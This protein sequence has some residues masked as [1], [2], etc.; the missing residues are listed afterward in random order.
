MATDTLTGG[1]RPVTLPN[2]FPPMPAVARILSRFD[3]DQLSSFIAVAI[4]LADAM[5]GD[6]DEEDGDSHEDDDPR[7]AA[8]IEWTALEPWRRAT[9]NL[10]GGDHEDAEPNGDE[11]D[12]TFA[13]DEDARPYWTQD[14][15]AGC[16]VS[17]PGG[18][19]IGE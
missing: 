15:G 16:P 13:E 17:D 1:F 18:T 19:D 2:H 8:Y 3:R 9:H 10:C 6:P 5:D 12:C 11:Q 14:I 4:D 7:E